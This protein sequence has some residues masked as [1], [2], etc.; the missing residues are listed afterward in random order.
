MPD[1]IYLIVKILSSLEWPTI[2]LIIF[3][4][5]LMAFIIWWQKNHNKDGRPNFINHDGY[6]KVVRTAFGF[7][8]AGQTHSALEIKYE[9]F[10]VKKD[11]FD[12]EITLEETD[13]ADG[14]KFRALAI[15]SVQLPAD[16][17]DYVA[18]RYFVGENPYHC[19]DGMV[20]A[21]LSLAF[22]QSL[23]D[24]ILEYDGTTPSEQ[25]KNTYLGDIML[26]AMELGHIVTGV[27]TFNIMEIR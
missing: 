25:L 6:Y 18:H 11:P 5:A 21:D 23:R 20:E 15:A 8:E 24:I 19:C 13:G 10:Y 22:S 16:K 14:K 27:S 4:V 2:L 17:V 12:I 9:Y 1:P 3:I 26:K 7:A